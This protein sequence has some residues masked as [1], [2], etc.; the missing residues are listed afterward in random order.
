VLVLVNVK[1]Y[2]VVAL[3]ISMCTAMSVLQRILRPPVTSPDHHSHTISSACAAAA[4]CP[5]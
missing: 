3:L 1:L 4:V 5:D 2:Y